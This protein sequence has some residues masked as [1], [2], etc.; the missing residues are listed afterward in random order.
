MFKKIH[1]FI[2][3]L[4]V[5]A[6]SCQQ[7]QS[8]TITVVNSSDIDLTDKPV[9]IERSAIKSIPEGTK[10]PTLSK[11][12]GIIIP[13]QAEDTNGDGAW[14]QLAFVTDIA[15][16]ETQELTLAWVD[17]MPEYTKRTSI[18]FGKRDGKK[19]PVKPKTSDTL[20]ADQIHARMGYQPYQTDGPSWENDKVGFRH[21][22]DGRNAKDLFGKKIADI[23]PEDVGISQSGGVE[24]NY[25]EMKP[26]GRD[27]L[28]VG[29]SVGLGGVGLI[30]G[31]SL[32]RLGCLSGDTL[33]NVAQSIFNIEVEGPV[34]SAFTLDY[35]GWTPMEGKSL[36]VKENVEIWPGIYAYQNTVELSGLTDESL[37]IGLVKTVT[38]K[39]LTEVQIDDDW[40][41]IFTHDAQG[42]NGEWIIGMGLILPKY[43]YEGWGEAPLTADI[44]NTYYAKMSVSNNEPLTY[45]AVAGWELAPDKGFDDPKVFQDYIEN[46][47]K[48]LAVALEV[49][50][51]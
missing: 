33:T 37:V 44:T 2:F 34:H 41:I 23:S 27:I 10:Y 24:D 25:H 26:W 20:M 38:E 47:A 14:D 21:Y 49:S 22:F 29:K 30:S 48:Q 6:M 46:L 9:T 39:P 18:R 35:S 51:K 16:A 31:D 12:D 40:M 19:L 11:A 4:S 13:S 36:S 17:E 8:S 28:P 32:L 1:L 43:A 7:N 5:A 45:Y 50:V 3:L 42:Y 15:A